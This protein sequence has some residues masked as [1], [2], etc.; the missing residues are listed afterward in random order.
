MSY[1]ADQPISAK[2]N[3]D[4]LLARAKMSDAEYNDWVTLEA[5]NHFDLFRREI[6]PNATWGWWTQEIAWQLQRF[7]NDMVDGKRPKLA[8]SAPPQHGKSWAA[9]DFIAYV[10]GKLPD[11]KTIFGSY[12]DDLGVR[13]NND[14]QRIIT[15]E[16]FKRIFPGTKISEE[17]VS[18][19]GFDRWKRN[20]SL[21]EFINHQGSFR[22]TT[23]SGQINGL[24]LHFGVIDDPLKGREEARRVNA[25]NKVWDW[26]ADDFLSRFAK[27]AALLVVMTRWDVDDLLGRY[28]ERFPELRMLRYPA[29]AEH[30]E[31]F[32]RKGEP[33]FPELKPLDFLLDRKKLLT[34]PSWESIYQ[35]HPIVVGGGQFP[36]EKLKVLPYFDTSKITHSIRYWDKA[37]SD[38]EDA[39]FTAGV[40]MHA[41]KDGS[42]V[43]S[44]VARGQWTAL[45]REQKIRTWTEADAAQFTNYEIYCEQEPGSGGKESAE[46]TIRHL[47]G[48]RVYADKVTG[49]KEIRAEPLAAQV[50]GGNVHLVAGEWVTDFLDELE[51]FPSGKWKDQVDA[52]SG[53]FSARGGPP[54]I[55]CSED[56]EPRDEAACALIWSGGKTPA[57][58][59]NNAPRATAGASRLA[60]EGTSR[61][62]TQRF[63]C[64]SQALGREAAVVTKPH[65]MIKSSPR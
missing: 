56:S 49:H 7:Y 6:R 13:T 54:P 4:A 18:S 35:Q 33:L 63:P 15:G 38:T 51:V 42:F 10:A 64:A 22:N 43:I 58:E 23:V 17:A 19:G 59:G 65:N 12:S 3:H 46:A 14:L 9:T 53:A 50:Q 45:V 8:I 32:R 2:I 47:A 48:Y 31:R 5:R 26:F 21:I 11:R 57:T 52:A 24:E 37:A 39:A 27:D 1:I 62:L 36:I 44:H 16:P 41:M 60:S 55:S 25:R 28:M 29:I 61:P 34:Q 40:L 30:D 20:S